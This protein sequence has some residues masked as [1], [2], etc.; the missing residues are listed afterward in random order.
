MDETFS[1]LRC[2][3]RLFLPLLLPGMSAQVPG[4]QARPPPAALSLGPVWASISD[5][6]AHLL[7]PWTQLLQRTELLE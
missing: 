3:L 4:L 7:S 2:S 1:E 5:S 6:P